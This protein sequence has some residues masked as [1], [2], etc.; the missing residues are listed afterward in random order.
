MIGRPALAGVGWQHGGVTL[1]EMSRKPISV[2]LTSRGRLTLPSAIRARLCLDAADKCSVVMQAD[3]TIVLRRLTVATSSPLRGLLAKP[4]RALSVAEM[5][6][7][8]ASAVALDKKA[9][10]TPTHRLLR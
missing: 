3:G 1:A 6:A 2:T 7:G 5:D 8:I 9:A 4:A 10:E